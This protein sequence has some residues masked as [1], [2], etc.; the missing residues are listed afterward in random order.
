MQKSASLARNRAHLRALGAVAVAAA[1]K[2]RDHAPLGKAAYGAQHVFHAVRRMGIVDENRVI[3]AGRHDLHAALDAVRCFERRRRVRK[4]HAERAAHAE[5]GQRIG[6][7]ELSRD[8]EMYAGQCPPRRDANKIHAVRVQADILGH[9][10]GG[11]V[12]CREGLDGARRV[13]QHLFT[14]RIVHIDDALVTDGEQE[15]LG[16]P[17]FLP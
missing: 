5:R 8:A 3:G 16:L 17:V 15:G 10:V 4:R 1:S 2:Q 9:E 12:L 14:R 11:I 13:E 6:N 7:R